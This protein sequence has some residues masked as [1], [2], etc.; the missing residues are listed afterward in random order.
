MDTHAATC[1][2]KWVREGKQLLFEKA[3]GETGFKSQISV[4]ANEEENLQKRS[5]HLQK[6][7]WDFRGEHERVLGV[8]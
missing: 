7:D 1:S 2:G 6:A 8:G 4:T 3:V 5:G